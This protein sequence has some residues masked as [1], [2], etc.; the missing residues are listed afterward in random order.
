ML[1][2]IYEVGDCFEYG[3]KAVLQGRK[4]RSRYACFRTI[5]VAAREYGGLH[6]CAALLRNFQAIACDTPCCCS[7]QAILRIDM[8]RLPPVVFRSCARTVLMSATVIERFATANPSTRE[9]K[10]NRSACH[11]RQ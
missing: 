5:R 6:W 7:L 2:G 9:H 8:N 3:H 10:R 11:R 1:H 4:G